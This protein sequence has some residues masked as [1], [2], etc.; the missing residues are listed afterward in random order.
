[1]DTSMHVKYFHFKV[2]PITW[3]REVGFVP[4]RPNIAARSC[5]PLKVPALVLPVPPEALAVGEV[6][7]IILTMA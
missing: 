1:M 2:V 3:L 7:T 5:P 4:K 6:D